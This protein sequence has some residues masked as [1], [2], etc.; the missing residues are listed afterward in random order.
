MLG[1]GAGLGRGGGAPQGKTEVLVY[2][3]DF[4][5]GLDGWALWGMPTGSSINFNQTIDGTSGW[6][7]VTYFLTESGNG[8][9]TKSL[10]SVPSEA[11]GATDFRMTGKM[12]FEETANQ[13]GGSVFAWRNGVNGQYPTTN[14]AVNQTAT[15]NVTP[16]NPTSAWG[17]TI[18]MF[19]YGAGTVTT[20][21]AGAVFYIK[22]IELYALV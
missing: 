8:G 7:K 22:D 4:T 3:S 20:I 2:Q 6:L 11:Q 15:F 10:I 17:S 1:L 9:A 5:A 14:F 12:Y 16:N 13:W 19:S 21:S 18:P